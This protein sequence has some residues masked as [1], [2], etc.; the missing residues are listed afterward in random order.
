MEIQHKTSSPFPDAVPP[1]DPR[2]PREAFHRARVP[3]VY[4]HIPFCRAICPY[5]DFNTY[6]RKEHLIGDYVAAMLREIELWGAAVRRAGRAVERPVPS[7]YLGGGTP[8]LLPPEAVMRLVAA[9]RAVGGPAER[10]SPAADPVTEVT[11]EA[12]PGTVDE[13]YFRAVRAAGVNRISLGAQTFQARGLKRLGRGHGVGGTGAAIE[14]ARGAGIDNLSLDLM[15]GW[16]EQTVTEWADDLERAVALAPEHVSLYPLQVEAGTPFA[17]L[18]R[19]GRL[20]V[21]PDDTVAEMYEL[22][23]ARFTAAGYRH[24]EISSFARCDPARP[25][26]DFRSRHNLIYWWNAEYLGLGAGAHGFALGRRWVDTRRPERYLR[27]LL[28]GEPVA[29]EVEVIDLGREMSD[30]VIMGLRLDTGIDR[31]AFAARFGLSLDRLYGNEIAMLMEA[32]LLEAGE[33]T[34][35][36]TV[37]GR[38]VANE[39]FLRFLNAPTACF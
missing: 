39:V 37:G 29:E 22:A 25:A 33:E 17:R 2:E 38:F 36:L 10:P 4:L 31:R 28:A 27:Q 18:A 15:F 35:R 9:A 3:A 24:Y 20:P 16:P 14:A 13:A 34:I 21:P 11:L 5:C 30:T 12:N 26:R 32:G 8:S 6:A 23:H 19:Q 1:A 7:I